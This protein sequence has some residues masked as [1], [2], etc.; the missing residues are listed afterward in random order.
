MGRWDDDWHYE[1]KHK[2][3]RDWIRIARYAIY[4][5]FAIVAIVVLLVFIPRAGLTVE[6]MESGEALTTISIKINNNNP[7]EIH[8]VTVVF[9]DDKEKKQVFNSIGP[10]SSIFV[11]PDKDNLNFKKIIVTADNGK[12]QTTKYR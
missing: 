1:G 6:I 5:G 8:N 4:G 9:D 2:K 10:F 7:Q 11:T 12:L 3:S